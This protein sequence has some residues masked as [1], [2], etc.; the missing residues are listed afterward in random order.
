[1]NQDKTK[2]EDLKNYR[3]GKLTVLQLMSVLAILGVLIT[4]LL[5]YWF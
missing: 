2:E 1:M 5:K 3:L 4:I